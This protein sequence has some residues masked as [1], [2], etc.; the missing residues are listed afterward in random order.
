MAC[1]DTSVLI[2]LGRGPGSAWQ[3]RAQRA[4]ADLARRGSLLA[5]TRFNVAELWVGI[6]RA[7]DR[8]VEQAKVERLL[9]PLAVL[10]F[11][12]NGAR[13]FGQLTAHLQALGEPV[14]DMDA[15]IAAVALAHGH[16]ILTRNAKHFRR[17]PGVIVHTY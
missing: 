3:Q 14:G 6:F 1:L 7:P 9:A 12:A 2:D 17:I 13:L 4:V 10:E 16:E 5:T 11:D 8:P 15:L